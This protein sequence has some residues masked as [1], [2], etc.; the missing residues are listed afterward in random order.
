[1]RKLGLSRG[2]SKYGQGFSLTSKGMSIINLPLVSPVG[3]LINQGCFK[4]G[5]LIGNTYLIIFFEKLTEQ[6]SCSSEDPV[7]SSS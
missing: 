5:L 3:F 2:G 1:L 4:E 6:F 7:L